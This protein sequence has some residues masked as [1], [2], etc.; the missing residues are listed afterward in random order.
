MFTQTFF[1]ML[2]AFLLGLLLGWFLWGRLREQIGGLEADNARLK[3]DADRLKGELD[4]CARARGE[5]ESRLRELDAQLTELRARPNRTA[6]VTPAPAQLISRPP[7]T[8]EAAKP[9]RASG[10]AAKPAAKAPASRKAAAPKTAAAAEKVAS[11]RKAAAP[12]AAEKVAAPKKAAAPE[13]AAAAARTPA[14]KADDLRRMIGIGPVNARLLRKA[15]V[16]TFAQIAAWTAA[17]IQRIEETLEF[18]GRI[19]RERW[20]EQAK[21]L[22]AGDE[23]EFLRRFPTAGSENNT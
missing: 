1:Y 22:A 21:L 15:G 11:P 13:K 16:T 8:T 4:G 5:A 23:K 12:K 14:K 19:E 7:K 17:D 6:T 2:V 18:D 3:A 9:A 10:A 20:V